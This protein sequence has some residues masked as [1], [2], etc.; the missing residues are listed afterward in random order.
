M[1]EVVALAAYSL[2]V[3]WPY[4]AIICGNP[5]DYATFVDMLDLVD[6]HRHLPIF[7]SELTIDGSPLLNHGL[8]EAICQAEKELPYVCEMV[9]ALF[10]GCAEGWCQFTSEF[11][12]GGPIDTLPESLQHLVA[13]SATNDPNEGILG[14]MR[15]AAHFHP[16][17]STSNFSA[18]KRVHHNDTE[19][20]IRKIMTEL[21]DH[22]YVMRRVRKE[23][24]SGKIRKFNLE[25]TERIATKG[26]EARDHWEAL[27]EDQRLE[28]A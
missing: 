25:V 24:A 11:V 28:Q 26:R 20:F 3:S 14:T 15:I 5:S 16:N 22:T 2:F 1:S 17:I 23:D 9:T 13:V 19:N 7:Y 18:R 6:L 12:H 4:L 8:L 27:A 21:E 10:K